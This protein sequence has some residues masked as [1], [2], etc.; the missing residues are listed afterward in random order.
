MCV[1]SASSRCVTHDAFLPSNSHPSHSPIDAH[2]SLPSVMPG[3]SVTARLQAVTSAESGLLHIRPGDGH[4]AHS[5]T[6]HLT[7]LDSLAI[8]GDDSD[9]MIGPDRNRGRVLQLTQRD[10]QRHA[11]LKQRLRQQIDALPRVGNLLTLDVRSNDLR[12]SGDHHFPHI[13]ANDCY[14]LAFPIS[15]KCSSAI[16]HY[17]C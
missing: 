15:L 9:H 14:R 17:E 6:P 8:D 2:T 5:S 7:S 1:C 11:D 12:V 4:L 16:V 13:G 10:V 3:N